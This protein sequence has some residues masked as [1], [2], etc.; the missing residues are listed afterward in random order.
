MVIKI[1]SIKN[2][3]LGVMLLASAFSQAAGAAELPPSQPL[4]LP[5]PGIPTPDQAVRRMATN[6]VLDSRSAPALSRNAKPTATGIGAAQITPNRKISS[7]PLT[8]GLPNPS[9][10][11]S[12]CPTSVCGFVATQPPV[13]LGTISPSGINKTEQSK[14]TDFKTSIPNTA[15]KVDKVDAVP[16][17]ITPNDQITTAARIS[18]S[19]EPGLSKDIAFGQPATK[20]AKTEKTDSKIETQPTTNQ[21]D[22]L[23]TVA[24]LTTPDK[25]IGIGNVKNQITSFTGQLVANSWK[26]I[27][28]L[29]KPQLDSS[30]LN[31]GSNSSFQQSDSLSFSP[32]LTLGNAVETA[33]PIKVS[34]SLSTSPLFASQELV[35]KPSPVVVQWNQSSFFAKPF[36]TGNSKLKKFNTYQGFSSLNRFETS[37]KPFNVMTFVATV[38]TSTLSSN[39]FGS[40]NY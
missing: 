31:I 6:V 19:T 17:T 14:F 30:L 29:P 7:L 10:V 32:R 13:T 3:L 34:S 38:N 40:Q 9:G 23:P 8:A 11:L 20:S 35:V 36:S 21:P 25:A 22:S 16:P 28:V 12:S 2:P 5:T 24:N 4:P 26:L 18:L 1:W 15:L 37:A 33:P 39:K 27:T